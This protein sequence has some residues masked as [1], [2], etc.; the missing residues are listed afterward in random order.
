VVVNLIE[1]V[2]EMGLQLASLSS[3]GRAPRPETFVTMNCF[4]ILNEQSEM[5]RPGSDGQVVGDV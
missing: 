5:Y 4:E 2:P 3:A 1:N